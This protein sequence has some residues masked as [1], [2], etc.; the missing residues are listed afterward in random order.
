MA[1]RRVF[2]YRDK[3]GHRFVG[4]SAAGVVVQMRRF[5]WMAAGKRPYMADVAARVADVFPGTTVS[6][7]GPDSFLA[8][9]VEA[10]LLIDDTERQA[11]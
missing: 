1:L 3:A 11:N 8:S 7:D 5:A 10:G 9:L 2:V 6:T 4:F